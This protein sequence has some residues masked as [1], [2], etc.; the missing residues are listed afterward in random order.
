SVA[1]SGWTRFS[2]RGR[3]SVLQEERSRSRGR[4]LPPPDRAQR[5]TPHETSPAQLGERALATRPDLGPPLGAHQVARRPLR[6][7]R[8]ALLLLLAAALGT[9]AVTHSATWARSQADQA[10]YEAGADVRV[11]TSPY[12]PLPAWAGGAAI[13]AI[14]GVRAVLPVARGT[15]DRGR[16]IRSGQLLGIDPGLAPAVVGRP[17]DER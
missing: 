14:P 6:Y 2:L 13:R 15:S 10:A 11:L 17:A 4:S 8:S 5:R 9:L 12:Q 7:T 3:R 1:R 16:T